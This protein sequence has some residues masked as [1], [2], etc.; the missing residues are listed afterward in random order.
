MIACDGMP[1]DVRLTPNAQ[2][3]QAMDDAL[4]HRNLIGPFSSTASMMEALDND[5][6]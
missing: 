1:F 6:A 5:D 2:T 3:R 4:N